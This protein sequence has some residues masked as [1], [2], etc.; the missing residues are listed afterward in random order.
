M[1]IGWLVMVVAITSSPIFVYAQDTDEADLEVSGPDIDITFTQ[2]GNPTSPAGVGLNSQ[3][4]VSALIQNLG[5]CYIVLGDNNNQVDYAFNLASS[6]TLYKVVARVRS[7][8]GDLVTVHTW[9]DA[10]GTGALTTNST[11][12]GEQEAT[13]SGPL[14]AGNRVLRFK[15]FSGGDVGTDLHVDW[16]EL[17]GREIVSDPWVLVFKREAETYDSGGS[18]VDA[19]HPQN[20][21]VGIYDGDP[22]GGG[23]QIGSN[24]VA[25]DASKIT[26]SGPTTPILTAGGSNSVMVTWTA[27]LLSS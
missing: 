5:I 11:T 7:S 1:L 20:V 19:I 21:T 17:Y 14:P 15:V 23:I 16:I 27:V 8:N 18:T 9:V 13:P 25:S 6:I 2:L 12:W 10:L 24:Q 22:D 3:V 26:A 4:E